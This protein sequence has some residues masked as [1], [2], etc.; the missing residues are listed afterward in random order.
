MRR[1]KPTIER[2][3][4]Q[5]LV[6]GTARVAKASREMV[7]GDHLLGDEEH[8]QQLVCSFRDVHRYA[9]PQIRWLIHVPNGGARNKVVAAKMAGQGVKKGWPDW[10]WPL[11]TER[12]VGLAIELKRPDGGDGLSSDQYDALA[13][14]WSNDWFACCAHGSREAIRIIKAYVEGAI[15]L[16][17]NGPVTFLADSTAIPARVGKGKGRTRVDPKD[18]CGG[19]LVVFADPGATSK[20]WSY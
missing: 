13:F 7:S 1:R 15:E 17:Y 18:E 5:L 14:L 9:V 4:E 2:V 12:F 20:R 16:R 8:H 19:E 11:R 6:M 3:G 10:Q